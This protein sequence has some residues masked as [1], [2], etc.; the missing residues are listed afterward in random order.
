M[1]VPLLPGAIRPLHIYA[2]A[3]ESFEL[4]AAIEMS[5]KAVVIVAANSLP[6]AEHGWPFP[7][8]VEEIPGCLNGNR[9]WLAS[10]E[11]PST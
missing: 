1:R 8:T 7:F 4:C 10:K 6:L 3:R 11:S 9:H 5:A 2:A